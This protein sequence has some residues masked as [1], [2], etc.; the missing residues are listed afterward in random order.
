M[1][2]IGSFLN[3]LI[4]PV[5]TIIGSVVAATYTIKKIEFDKKIVHLDSIAFYLMYLIFTIVIWMFF[6]MYI[7]SGI[8]VINE[9][10]FRIYLFFWFI[11]F[12]FNIIVGYPIIVSSRNV[13][14][15]IKIENETYLLKK[16][17]TEKEETTIKY[18]TD[19]NLKEIINRPNK[20]TE[21]ES[22]LE[23]Y[24]REVF[25]S[26]TFLNS[27]Y[28]V[29]QYNNVER[30]LFIVIRDY[31]RFSKNKCL[32]IIVIIIEVALII[33][34]VIFSLCKVCMVLIPLL[35]IKIGFIHLFKCIKLL[36]KYYRD[37][38]IIKLKALYSLESSDNNE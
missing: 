5:I 29:Y 7:L 28:S 6:L 1:G 16:L 9:F 21:K 31:L 32:N 30:H 12:I 8:E 10:G 35:V 24:N 20:R 23:N 19:T 34:I 15:I 25:N 22:S 36:N 37:N 27:N 14:R 2:D 4:L 17:Y 3:D 13:F 38:N 18:I 33:G 11:L 26:K